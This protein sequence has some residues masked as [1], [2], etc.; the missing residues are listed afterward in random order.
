MDEDHLVAAAGYVSLNPARARLV[1][2]PWDWPWSSVRAHLAGV[3]DA[4]VS[5]R[6][7]LDRIPDF[8]ALLESASENGFEALR[9]AEGTGRPAGAPEFLAGLERLLG[10]PIARR[11]PGRKPS[12][13]IVDQLDLLNRYPVDVFLRGNSPAGKL[14]SAPRGQ[15]RSTAGVRLPSSSS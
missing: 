3:D 1:S 2:R 5:V 7:V 8:K 4:L 14:A 13:T 9:H 12:A 10:R 6:P 15:T 11:A